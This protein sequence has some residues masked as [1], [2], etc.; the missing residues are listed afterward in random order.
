MMFCDGDKAKT[1][2]VVVHSQDCANSH[3]CFPL[4]AFDDFSVLGDNL[5]TTD[6]DELKEKKL[7]GQDSC[8][9]RNL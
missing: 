9:A 7:M 5:L 2:V 4:R 1:T 6:L 3:F 8:Y